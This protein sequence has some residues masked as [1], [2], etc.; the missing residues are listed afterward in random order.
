MDIKE[1]IMK[2]KNESGIFWR[3]KIGKM[4]E[5]IVT[6]I[7]FNSTLLAKSPISIAIILRNIHSLKNKHKSPITIATI[8]IVSGIV[9]SL[10]HI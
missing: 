1:I 5:T 9:P 7:Q 10:R 3:M 8:R 2:A 4:T 6:Q